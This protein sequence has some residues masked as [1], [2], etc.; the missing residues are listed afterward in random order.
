MAPVSGGGGGGGGSWLEAAEAAD[1][2]RPAAAISN[3]ADLD[4]GPLHPRPPSET[5][6]IMLVHL[7]T[8]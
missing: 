1:D 8:M 5:S 7:S 3:K 2:A 6:A 4:E